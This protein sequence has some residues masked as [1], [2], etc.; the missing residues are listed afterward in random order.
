MTSKKIRV[1]LSQFQDFLIAPDPSAQLARVREIY[2]ILLRPYR[3]GQDYWSHFREG[4]AEIHERG[5]SPAELD[6]II[7]S[8]P[9]ARIAQ[10]KSAL[11]GY[12]RFWGIKNIQL[13]K[14]PQPAKWERGRLQIR[15]NP[16]WILRVGHQQLVMKLHLKK[17]YELDQRAANPVL[18]ML[19]EHFGPRVGGPQV[20]LLDVHRGKLWTIRRRSIDEISGV[21]HMQASAFIAGWDQVE[22]ELEAA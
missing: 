10:Y 13:E 14:T 19:T 4:V 1:S 16:E 3:P 2:K 12:R 15:V 20:G 5:G 22:A 6:S 11:D 9:D 18:L 17:R 21:V 7:D 8:A